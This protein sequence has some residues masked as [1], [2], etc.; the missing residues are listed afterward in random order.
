MARH[1]TVKQVLTHPV[2]FLAFG[3]GSGLAPYA[4]GTVGT[5]VAI[6]IYLVINPFSPLVYFICVVLISLL[7]VVIAG[8]SARLLQVHDHGGIVIDEICGYLL[9]MFLAPSGWGWIVLGFVLFRV[10]DICKPWPIHWLD[11]HIGGGL[12]I[13]LDDL[14]AAIYALLSLQLVVLAVN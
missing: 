12:G 11:R 7:G 5:I 4:P 6:P 2:H 10:F 8:Q 9:T 3:F 14:M 1:P 13:M